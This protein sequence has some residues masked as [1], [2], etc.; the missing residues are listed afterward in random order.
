MSTSTRDLAI[1]CSPPPSSYENSLKK[2]TAYLQADEDRYFSRPVN[3]PHDKQLL[4]I[5]WFAAWKEYIVTHFVPDHFA[6]TDDPPPH[7]QEA[8][9][10]ASVPTLTEARNLVARAAA[11]LRTG[12]ELIY[13]N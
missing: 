5:Q 12:Q 9:I 2:M 7:W 4:T 3:G 1:P 10:I 6:P 11:R 13:V 8:G